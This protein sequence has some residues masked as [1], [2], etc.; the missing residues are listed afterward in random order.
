MIVFSVFTVQYLNNIVHTGCKFPH[1]YPNR[2]YLIKIGLSNIAEHP[3]LN[4]NSSDVIRNMKS[5]K[6]STLLLKGNKLHCLSLNAFM[7][8]DIHELNIDDNLF[9]CVPQLALVASTLVMLSIS[10]NKLDQCN[11]DV[12]W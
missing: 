2:Q 10:R 11:L 8:R 1:S 9:T 7:G 4:E 3:A 6:F 12:C 5:V